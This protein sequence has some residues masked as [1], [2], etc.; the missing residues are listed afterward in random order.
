MDHFETTPIAVDGVSFTHR[1]ADAV[2]ALDARAGRKLWRYVRPVPAD[3]QVCCGRVTAASRFWIRPLFVGTTGRALVALNAATA[4]V[5]GITV[6]ADYKSGHSL[7]MAPLAI[8]GKVIVGIAGGEFGV[9]GFIDAYDAKTGKQ[10]WRFWTV[11]APG[12][13]GNQSWGGDSWKTGG[14]PAWVTGSYDPELNTIYWGTGNPAP[15]WNAD[16][17]PG[18]NLYSCSVLAL[19]AATGKLKW[20]FQFT[21]HDSHDYDSTTIPLLFEGRGEG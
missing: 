2:T 20:H 12:E 9:R 19:D 6:V 1:T 14:A 4:R 15:D 11:P 13:P 16:V 5:L 8:D 17:R 3:I 10:L 18:D 21:P 7:T